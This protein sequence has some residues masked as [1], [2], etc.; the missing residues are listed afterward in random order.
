MTSAEM[1]EMPLN[2]RNFTDLA[3][4]VP[5]VNPGPQGGNASGIVI[6]G[7]R[8]DNTNFIIDGFSARDPLFGASL[9]TPNIDATQE[10]K[11]MTNNFSA[12]YG[13]MAGGLMNMALKSG[14]NQAH[15]SLFEFLRN[16]LVDA[17]NFFDQ[18]KSELRRNQFGGLLSGP[19]VIPKLYKGRDRTFFLFS[20]ESY[21]QVQ[22]APALGVVPTLA[23]RTGDFSATSPISDPL[24]TG[25]CAGSTGIGTCFPGNVIPVSRLSPQALAAQK[26]Y[27]APNLTGLNNMSTDAVA[28]SDWNSMVLK[29]D[30]RIST[31]D[32]LSFRYTR[33]PSTSYSPYATPTVINGN[34]T[35]LFGSTSNTTTTL[36][37][38]TYTRLF[39]PTLINELRLGY[40]RT[41]ADVDG[42]FQGTNYDTLFGIQGGTTD[43][44]LIGFPLIVPSGYQQLGSAAGLPNVY[45]VN[46]LPLGDTLTWVKG[47]HLVKAGIDVLHSQTIN[48]FVTN[49]RGLYNFTGYWTGQSYADFLLGYLNSASGLA[50]STVSHLLAT[51]YGSFVQDDWKVHSRLT[52][53]LGLRWEINKPPVDSAGRLSNFDPALNQVVIASEKTLVGTGI[54]ITDPNAVTTAAQAGLP[55][56]LIFTRYKAFAP[57]FG[58]AW[59][60][61]GGNRTVVRGGYGVFYGGTIQ[62]AMRSSMGAIFPFVIAQTQ[63]RNATNPLALTLANPF[64]VAPSLSGSLATVTLGVAEIHPP[65]SYLQSWNLTIE[66]EIGVSSALKISYVGSKG[67][68]SGMQNSLNQPY[69]R[70]AALPGGILPYPGWGSMNYFSLEGNSLYNG[71]TVTWQRRFVRGFFYTLNYTYSKSIDEISQSTAYPAGGVLGLQNVRCLTCDRGRSDWDIPHQFTASFSWQCPYRNALVHGWQIAGTS[72]L[73]SGAPFTPVVTSAN[74]ALGEASRP[75]RIAKGTI[76]NPGPNMWFDVADLPRVPDGAFGFGNAGRN[77]LDSPGRVEVNLSLL[78]NFAVRE[79]HHF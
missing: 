50:E 64:P 30:E 55:Q 35:G 52:L 76:P 61:F 6:N 40:T 17:R 63:N 74:L 47:A 22:G 32:T 14:A 2:G 56:S 65:L 69:N 3:L 42:T 8:A 21:R 28:P 58:F 1:L 48:A 23:Q 36:A 33:R 68:H 51:S 20:W 13:R 9:T 11:M 73:Y 77:I 15:G 45:F 34:N 39:R 26:F 27:P 5:G 41:A 37:G 66:R 25:K 19:V 54:T 57:R 62:N 7:A 16:D 12:E 46:T 67:T 60:P 44:H 75:N 79:Q 78:K 49:S 4:L 29:F 10:F 31:A 24:S 18:Q 38:L 59:R 71:A 70:S 43:P 53:N 72:R